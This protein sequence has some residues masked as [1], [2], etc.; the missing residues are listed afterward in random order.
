MLIIMKIFFLINIEKMI[1][2]QLFQMIGE[3]GLIINNEKSVNLTQK[4]LLLFNIKK[5]PLILKRKLLIIETLLID[6]EKE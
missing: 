4:K 3:R 2:N 1:N 6:N 5:K